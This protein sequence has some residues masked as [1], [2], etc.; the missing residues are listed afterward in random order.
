[1]RQRHTS[2]MLLKQCL[3]IIAYLQKNI[4][5]ATWAWVIR[6]L[7]SIRDA[8][9]W[10][11]IAV[12]VTGVATYA[13]YKYRQRK[14]IRS[15]LWAWS[16]MSK[17]KKDSKSWLAK[18]ALWQV[19]IPPPKEMHHPHYDVIKSNEQHQFDLLYMPHNLFQ[20]NTYKYVL[21]GSNVASRCK[22]TRPLRTKNSSEVAFVLEAIYKK[23]GVFQYPKT[24]QCDNGWESKNEVTKLLKK[25][26]A[27]IRRATA[28]YKH[29]YRAFVETFNKESAKLL[30]KPMDAQELQDPK[31]ILRFGLKIWI[32]LWTKWTTTQNCWWLVGNLRMQLN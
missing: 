21:T 31:H 22:V 13:L 30:F 14:A 5:L 25:H 7:P 26:N 11:T 3:N 2:T 29:T 17:P 1:M 9:K 12:M 24:F 19:H 16:F 15:I 32:K 18:L 6:F 20:G 23:I 4:A 10:R 8:K 27:E 28:K